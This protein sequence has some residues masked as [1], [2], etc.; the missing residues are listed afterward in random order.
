MRRRV[1][2]MQEER[3]TQLHLRHSAEEKVTLVKNLLTT[4]CL[5]WL[6]RLKTSTLDQKQL[7]IKIGRAK[8]VFDELRMHK[9]EVSLRKELH[10]KGKFEF[11]EVLR[12]HLELKKGK[13]LFSKKVNKQKLKT[14][15]STMQLN[16]ESITQ[17]REE[18]AL[19]LK[20]WLD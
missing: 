10:L 3:E 2:Q 5:T 6:L 1:N 4:K 12:T 15:L 11:L 9:K 18:K 16:I 8:S 17:T 13:R 20:L 14:S 19:Q 7:K